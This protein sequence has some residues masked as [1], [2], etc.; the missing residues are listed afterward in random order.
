MK[1]RDAVPTFYDGR[2]GFMSDD[3]QQMVS[4][5]LK[6]ISNGLNEIAK[7]IEALSEADSQTAP[8]SKEKPTKKQ[9]PAKR[10]NLARSTSQKKKPTDTD[11]VFGIIAGSTE[12]M[13]TDGLSQETGFDKEK[14]RNIVQRLKKQNRI[15]TKK[16]GVYVVNG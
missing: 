2:N 9:P 1:N 7:H 10:K 13:T 6:K 15:K 14:I 12:G 8:A 16:R 4:D 11:I 5:G 3:F